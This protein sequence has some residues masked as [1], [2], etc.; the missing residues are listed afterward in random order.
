[1]DVQGLKLVVT[2][3]EPGAPP[4]QQALI[5]GAE[6][7]AVVAGL[8]R[9]MAELAA[10]A[11][12]REEATRASCRTTKRQPA[13]T[14]RSDGHCSRCRDGWPSRPRAAG[15]LAGW[16]ELAQALRTP[17]PSR[18]RGEHCQQEE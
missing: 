11:Q 9:R 17:L 8:E 13:S 16:D 15:R 7:G 12:D 18:D 2:R 6:T 10:P 4:A 5:K 14:W 3:A 1:M